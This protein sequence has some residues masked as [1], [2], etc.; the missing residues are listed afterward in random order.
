MIDQY[1][2]HLPILSFL[3]NQISIKTT[4]IRT[5]EIGPGFYST[6]LIN[7][8]SKEHFILE[9]SAYWKDIIKHFM[10]PNYKTFWL[11]VIPLEE[12]L[13][14]FNLIFIDN[15]REVSERRATISYVLNSITNPFTTVVIHDFESYS[16][17]INKEFGDS[18]EVIIFDRFRPNTG[19]LYFVEK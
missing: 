14:T 13:N 15:G 17:F 3:F 12:E 11:D 10:I 19:V 6:P 1:A 5:L 4:N 2:S 9:D 7:V 16:D 8:A 18:F